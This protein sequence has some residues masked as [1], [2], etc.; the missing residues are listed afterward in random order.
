MATYY[1]IPLIFTIELTTKEKLKYILK[2][3]E[4]S[5]DFE[6]IQI[7]KKVPGKVFKQL[8]PREIEEL[9]LFDSSRE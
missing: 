5:D 7:L 3:F 9:R 4:A 8:N 1:F 2:G 6:A